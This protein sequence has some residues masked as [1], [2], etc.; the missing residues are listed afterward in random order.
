[1]LT[2]SQTSLDLNNFTHLGERS[3]CPEVN[4]VIIE[5]IDCHDVV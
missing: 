4:D 2:K 3:F 1:M 5:V